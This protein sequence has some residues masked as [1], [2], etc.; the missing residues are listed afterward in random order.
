MEGDLD[1][2]DR[3]L[4]MVH[5]EVIRLGQVEQIVRKSTVVGLSTAEEGLQT[6]QE[7]V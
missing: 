6:S 5:F 3:R 7:S 1:A 4:P 2:V